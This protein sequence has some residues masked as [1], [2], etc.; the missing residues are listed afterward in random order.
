M[1]RDEY[2][3]TLMVMLGLAAASLTGLVRQASI[4][5]Q[6]GAGRTTDIFL[7]AFAAPEF[8]FIAL[9]IILPPA[10]IPLFVERR[11]RQG[12]V[13]SWRFGRRVAGASLVLFL[14]LAAVIGLGAPL[15]VTWLAP[16]FAGHERAQAVTA[17]RMMAP[18]VV[19]MGLATLMG[20]TLQV[21]RRF[22][23]PALT[24]AVYNLTFVAVLMWA[25]VAGSLERAA[26]GVLLGAAAACGFQLSLLWRV[27]PRQQLHP[28]DVKGSADP[29]SVLQVARLAGP[30]AAGYTAHHVILLVDR[31]MATAL[32]AGSVAALNYAYHVA[33]VVGQLSGLAV[34]TVVF[35]RLAEQI[36]H[37]DLKAARASLSDALR[38]VRTIGLPATAGL[39]LFRKAIMG[40]LFQHGAFDQAATT[41]VSGPL[42]WYALAVLADALCQPL[43]RAIY[44]RR[45]MW[46]VLG[47]NTL[48]TGIRF[49][50]NVALIGSFGIEG[51]AFSAFLGLSTQA[52]V[53]GWLVMKR[54]GNRPHA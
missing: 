37:G 25:P 12:E 16:G 49:A 8:V 35:P 1:Q 11:Q 31:A 36:S 54:L 51:L 34:A 42:V 17:V 18:A 26:W 20:A 46:T 10:F 41:L 15:Y 6:L 44:A 4:A 9:P 45:S 23:R 32:G 43:W 53:L 27:A 52:V 19:L 29:G 50:C 38:F 40:L 13:G 33:L 21:Y 5:H 14:L 3:A 22:A 48:Q 47:V 2:W 24:A 28:D 7:I 39:I 30:L